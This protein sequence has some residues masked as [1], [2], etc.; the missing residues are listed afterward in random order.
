[1]VSLDDDDS[2][3]NNLPSN[4]IQIPI[5]QD[6]IST[7]TDQFEECATRE[8][9][10]RILLPVIHTPDSHFNDESIIL[11][12]R[13]TRSLLAAS[14]GVVP[15]FSLDKESYKSLN[16]NLLPTNKMYKRELMHRQPIAKSLRGKKICS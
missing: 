7:T 6:T 3:Y 13:R 15:D 10:D 5:E 9:H 16:K 4:S 12:N 11:G 2:L 14:F 8:S 1:M